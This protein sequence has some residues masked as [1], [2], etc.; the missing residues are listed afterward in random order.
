MSEHEY[1]PAGSRQLAAYLEGRLSSGERE[2]FEKHLPD[3]AVCAEEIRLWER[4]NL[5]P[6]AAPGPYFRREFEAMLRREAD[7][8]RRPGRES[9]PWWQR[10]AAAWAAAA[11]LAVGAFWAGSYRGEEK[12]RAEM[13][14][15][16]EEL[17]GMRTLVAM[18]LMQQQSA[19]ERLRGVNYTVR[20]ENPDED[21]VEAL[22]RTLRSD[23][24]VDVRMAAADALR[25]YSGRAAVRMALV[26]SL[27]VQD[28][29]MMQMVLIDAL[30]DSRERR[31]GPALERLRQTPDV[32]PAVKTRAVKAL[33]ELAVQ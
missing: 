15:L 13:A 7:Q 8:M 14:E 16:R 33:R 30:V 6:E 24:S 26:E 29:P 2:S 9:P 19:V 5:L 25:K 21:V 3:C 1:C 23:S 18:S 4:L 31:A 22:V 27:A 32:D 11:M 12:P 17:R 28:S 10:P 20:M